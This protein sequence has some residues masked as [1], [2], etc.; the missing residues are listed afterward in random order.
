MAKKYTYQG[1]N[2]EKM[3][4]AVGVS[5]PISHKHAIEICNHLKKR[6]V[7]KAQQILEDVLDKKQAIPFKRYKMNVGHKPGKMAA[8]RYPEKASWEILNLINSAEANA[9][10][11][12]L[13]NDLFITHLNANRAQGFPRGGRIPGTPKGAHVEIVIE[14]KKV[15]KKQRTAKKEAKP[16]EPKKEVAKKEE[17]KPEPKEEVKTEAPKKEST[18]L[19]EIK[20]KVAEEKKE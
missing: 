7:K 8:G 18:K 2:P 16:A 6:P 5:L 10:A 9:N 11:K 12:G 1:Y 13:S 17:K 3:A 20:K 4:R 19:E 15:E 14:E